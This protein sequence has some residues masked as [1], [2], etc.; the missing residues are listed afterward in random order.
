MHYFALNSL[1]EK[2][3][4]LQFKQVWAHFFVAIKFK[5]LLFGVDLIDIGFDNRL[6]W[7][8]LLEHVTNK[9]STSI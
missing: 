1:K 7:A 9:L 6:N 5:H 3:L 8:W 2:T 4:K